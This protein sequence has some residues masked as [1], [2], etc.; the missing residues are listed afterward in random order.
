MHREGHSVSLGSLVTGGFW[1]GLTVGRL[2][3]GLL[4]KHFSVQL[5]VLGGLATAVG[6]SFVAYSSA[7]APFVYPLIGVALASV[8]SMALIWY[9]VLCPNDSNGL[10]LLIFFMMAGGIIGPGVES[11]GV[12][13]FGIHAVP[14]VT[15]TLAALDLLVFASARRFAPLVALSP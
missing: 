11:L 12:S 8:Y 4:H 13:L 6:L 14:I 9:T 10:F 15:A 1:L 5:L 2:F 7:A 3:G